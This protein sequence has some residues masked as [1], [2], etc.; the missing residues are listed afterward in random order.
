M[1]RMMIYTWNDQDNKLNETKMGDHFVPTDMSAEEAEQHT[2]SYIRTQFP[3]RAKHFAR[4]R[5]LYKV[6][7]V[8]DI[9]KKFNKFRDRSHIDDL[10]REACLGHQGTQGREF[11]ALSFDDTNTRINKYLTKMGTPPGKVELTAWQA[12]TAEQVLQAVA[13]GK[14]TIMAELCARFGKTIWG[15]VLT[16]E[17]NAD[18]TIVVSYV[19]TSFASFE[20]EFVA[21]E[22]FSN[23]VSVDTSDV[24]Y[25]ERIDQAIAE[26]KQVVAFLSMC[27]GSKRQQKIDYLFGLNTNRLVLI[28]EADFGVHK[29]G[30]AKPLIDARQTND[31]IVL[32]TGTNA[33]KAASYWPI[34]YNLSVVYPEL[35][36]EKRLSTASKYTTTLKYFDINPQRHQLVVDVE[37]YQMDLVNAVEFSR[38]NDPDVFVDDGV[39]L[40]SWSKFAANPIRAKGFWTRMLQAVFLGQHG[41]DELNVE[42]QFEQVGDCR[43]AMMFLSGSMRNTNL[44][45]AAKLAQQALPGYIVKPI[46]GGTDDDLGMTNRSAEKEVN[47]IIEIAREKNQSV[48]LLSTGM[49][50]RSFSVAAISELYL[51]YDEGDNGATIQKISRALT[52]DTDSKVGRIVSLSFDPNRD[53]KFDALL[54]ETALN[55]KR[56][57]NIKSAKEAMRDVLRTVDIFR[58]SP[59]GAVKINGDEY[60]EQ[61][62]E[63][64]S[65]SRVVGKVADITKL[66]LAELNALAAGDARAF[67]AA[68]QKA[69]DSGKTKISTNS[70]DKNK[71]NSAE[72][73]NAK[74]IARARE[75]IV[76]IVENLDI[77]VKGTNSNNINTA[78][79]IIDE[80]LEH[81]Q[82]ITDEFG[83][84]FGLIK[85]LF[86][87]GVINLD[88]IELQVDS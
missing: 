51:A 66:S 27:V 20:K 40:P 30:Q 70:G 34:D 67:K 15:G 65:V 50:Q 18:L 63:R 43:V 16:R 84:E 2:I 48:L 42:Q 44:D 28:D 35:L 78:F 69:A 52:P 64:K 85:D 10:I 36:V 80:N 7:D 57:R 73:A 39:Y 32:M 56:S 71:N 58:C 62:I 53:D 60:L 38:T 61:A 1:S 14:K 83:V 87:T 4:G 12:R 33:D 82:A 54:I 88:L 76:T 55:Y 8:S 13:Q 29:A 77:V 47:D 11:H 59:D 37:F 9:A 3:R 68:R 41:W 86:E 17:T 46:Y 5:V 45:T 22:Q 81:Q 75:V 23:F 19:L 49:A 25:Q 72:M 6:W 21:F 24:D 26:N 74:L 31:V 79:Q